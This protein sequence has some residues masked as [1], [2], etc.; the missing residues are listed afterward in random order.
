MMYKQIL[1]VLLK[2]LD[3]V[4]TKDSYSIMNIDCVQID[5]WSIMD[6]DSVQTA[7]F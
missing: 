6:I 4:Q 5:S 1:G 7:D 3:S 2:Q